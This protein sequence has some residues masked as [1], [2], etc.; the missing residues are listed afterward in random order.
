MVIL[1][2]GFV[3]NP[4]FRLQVLLAQSDVSLEML[5]CSQISA[6]ISVSTMLVSLTGMIAKTVKVRPK[7]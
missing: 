7:L 3:Y 6:F 5:P 2:W 1:T 4:F